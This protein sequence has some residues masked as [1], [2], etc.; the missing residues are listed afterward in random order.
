MTSVVS[1]KASVYPVCCTA[2][3]DSMLFRWLEPKKAWTRIIVDHVTN[4]RA[5]R[6]K[7]LFLLVITRLLYQPRLVDVY[8]RSIPS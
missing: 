7:E 6:Q 5:A 3:P 2:L 4:G 8:A 1:L